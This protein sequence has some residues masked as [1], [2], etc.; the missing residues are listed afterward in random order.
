MRYFL[1]NYLFIGEEKAS[2]EA[3]EKIEVREDQAWIIRH[4]P[5]KPNT[6]PILI[7]FSI[8]LG[9]LEVY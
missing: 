7:L 2:L 5:G 3:L 9:C 1:K 4:K 8:K 6:L